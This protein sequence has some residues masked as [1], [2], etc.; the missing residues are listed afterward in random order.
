MRQHGQLV[1]G[2]LVAGAALAAFLMAIT[3]SAA[4]SAPRT[5]GTYRV[6]WDSSFGFSDGFDPTGEY[7]AQAGGIY[8]NLMLR[9]LIGY[10]HVAGPAGEK[11]VPDLATAVPRPTAGGTVYTFRLRRGVRFGP[12]VDRAVTSAD[13]AYSFERLGRP[14]DG[15][16]YA[17]FYSVIKGFTAYRAGKAKSIAGI[18]TPD[19]RTIVFTLDRPAGD[20]LYRLALAGTAPIPREVAH[21]FEGQAGRYGRDV[22][23][24]GPYMLAGMDQVDDSSCSRLHPASGFDGQTAMTLVRNPAYDAS[25]DSTAARQSL[26][27]EFR[28]TV[29]SNPE[30]ILNKVEKGDL[31]DEIAAIPGQTMERYTHSPQLRAS[32]RRNESDAIFYITMNLTQPPFDDIHVRRAMNWI[33]DKAALQQDWGG[34]TIGSIANHVIPDGIFGGEL[35]GYRPYG[36]PGDHGSLARAREAMKGSPYDTRG[37]GMCSAALCHHVLLLSDATSVDVRILSTLEADAAKIGITFTPRTV[38]GAFPVLE[39]TAQNIPIA[40]FPGWSKDYPDASTYFT[41]LDS[42]NILPTGN[43]NYSLVGITPA[44]AR[45]D[46]V[47]GNLDRIPNIDGRLDRCA[48]MLGARRRACYEAIDRY[49]TTDVVPSVPYL[50]YNAIHITSAKVARWGFDQSTSQTAYAHVAVTQ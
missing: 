24:T 49:V 11:L 37:D 13:V 38:A 32:L 46:G 3:A 47:T 50:D 44:A 42:R 22:V 12:P 9:T 28:F 7:S 31:D 39:S 19:A 25:T 36:T 5:G 14:K 45:S 43:I 29:D 10:D 26:P 16:E 2:C 6:G 20:F 33:V 40:D 27:D 17:F 1:Q 8:A 15:A 41:Q 4:P 18:S 21:C 34:P 30:D 35:E 48:V 23:S